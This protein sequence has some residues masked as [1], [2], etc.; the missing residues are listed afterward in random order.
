MGGFVFKLNIKSFLK[1]I[2][3]NQ[4]RLFIVIKKFKINSHMLFVMG[5]R[6]MQKDLN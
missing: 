2:I 4:V 1:E 6:D 3:F 5:N